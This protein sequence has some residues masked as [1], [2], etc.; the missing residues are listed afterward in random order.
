M[1]LPDY[2]YA[3]GKSCATGVL[4]AV[5]MIHMINE[6]AS[7]FGASCAPAAFVE[8]FGAWAFLLALIA[9]IVMHFIDSLIMTIT[10]SWARKQDTLEEHA[11]HGKGMLD[12]NEPCAELCDEG[13]GTPDDAAEPQLDHEHAKGCGDGHGHSHAIELPDYMAPA[14]RIV[15]A[16]SLEFGVTL[17]SVF[18][19]LTLGITADDEMR[20]LLTALVFHQLFEGVAM[21]SRLADATFNF[22]LELVFVFVFAFSAPVGVAAGT[23]AV[24]AS[25]SALTGS[26]YV[27]VSGI[28]DSVCGG[29]LLYLGFIL[30][31]VD[32]PADRRRFAAPGTPYRWFKEFGLF[33][34]LWVGAGVMALIGK[35]L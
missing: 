35:W 33:F 7:K 12:C 21:G 27:M 29:I 26:T 14:Q 34:A 16:L 18:V 10:Q 6:G 3:V 30:L 9:A 2:V 32:F 23:A 4:L 8:L 13:Q 5:A 24:S 25:R 19:G 1:R 31:L 11:S 22:C 20:V 17:H 28:C 15:A